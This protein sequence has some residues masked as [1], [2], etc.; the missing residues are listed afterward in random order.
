MQRGRLSIVFV[1]S[2]L[3]W[4]HP[5][6]AQT[7]ATG[8]DLP[9]LPNSPST[10]ARDY[11]GP[12]VCAS[13]HRAQ[14]ARQATS[15]MGLSLARPARAATLSAHPLMRYRRGKYTWTLRSSRGQATFTADDGKQ[16]IAA[17]LF[18]VI[19]SGKVFQAYLIEHRGAYARAAADYYAAQDKLGPEPDAGSALPAD[20]ESA[21]GKPLSAADVRGCFHCHSP[22]TVTMS[23][24]F[25]TT[26]IAPGITCEV[27]HGPGAKHGV[28]MRAGNRGD[29][30]IFNPAHL[31]PEWQTSFCDQCHESAA[32]MRAEHPHGVRSV[33]SPDYRLEQS[34]CFD[35]AD[36]RSSCFFCHDPH[37]PMERRMAAYDNKCLACHASR[38]AVAGAGRPGKACP[39][40]L[41][42]CA[43]C[44]MPRVTT[45]GS[46]IHFTDHRIRIAAAGAPYPE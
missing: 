29:T 28:A 22:A 3:A 9:W 5:A 15:E 18:M 40:A 30:A 34:R 6:V 10:R 21:L 23:G 1:A 41:S 7:P 24:A 17:P 14:A 36:A 38:G 37:A 8:T 44:H 39:V 43:G 12:I 19:G 32:N 45:P 42:N 11:S 26:R 4:A 35:A 33:I 2:I 13:C 20:L 31:R 46:P 27:C 25:D 16:K